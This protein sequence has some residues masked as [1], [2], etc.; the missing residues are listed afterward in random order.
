M[1]AEPKPAPKKVK[2]TKAVKTVD[3]N[4]DGLALDPDALKADLE[5]SFHK[6]DGKTVKH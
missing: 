6:S 1:Q 2:N 5:G 3:T 4:D